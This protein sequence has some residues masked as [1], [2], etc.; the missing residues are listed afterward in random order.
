MVVAGRNGL[1]G[2][3][4]SFNFADA[5]APLSPN[6]ASGSTI[7]LTDALWND[8]GI[9][10]AAITFTGNGRISSVRF[11]N[12]TNPGLFLASIDGLTIDLGVDTGVSGALSAFTQATSVL[13][14]ETS[15]GQFG[16]R[17]RATIVPEP[18]SLALILVSVL[19]LVTHR[20]HS[21]T[22]NAGSP[23]MQNS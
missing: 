21:A 5:V 22:T 9:A 15:T 6:L 19:N 20:L 12:Q 17:L 16:Y 11:I 2:V 1:K 18:S 13:L 4:F 14:V 10:P 8:G 7:D 3:P 23:Q